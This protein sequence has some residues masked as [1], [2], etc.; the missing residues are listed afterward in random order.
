MIARLV[1]ACALVLVLPTV[2]SARRAPTKA[3]RAA[4]KAAA[5]RSKQTAYLSCL[6]VDHVKVS[7]KGPWAGATIRS[8]DDPNDA[9]FGVF[10]RKPTGRWKLRRTGNGSVGCDVAPA[11]VQRDLDLGC[12]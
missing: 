10:S 8:C 2:A 5:E 12:G 3:E 6:E 11:R 7:T 1:L 9:I 4:I